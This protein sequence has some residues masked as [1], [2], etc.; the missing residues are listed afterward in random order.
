MQ[1]L[2][3]VEQ[4]CHLTLLKAR[5]LHNV[6]LWRSVH[7]YIHLT[8][9]ASFNICVFS[10]YWIRTFRLPIFRCTMLLTD[11]ADECKLQTTHY[12]GWGMWKHVRKSFMVQ[13]QVWPYVS[14]FGLKNLFV[15]NCTKTRTGNPVPDV[16]PVTQPTVSK[17]W[18]N[19]KHWTRQIQ[20]RTSFFFRSPSDSCTL[21]DGRLTPAP[22][23]LDYIIY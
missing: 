2:F 8:V 12:S 18:R 11:H 9:D 1:V 19:T 4:R 16:L 15:C 14:W 17:H 20:P 21:Y 10:L 3:I 6:A 23:S 5:W 7:L 22:L 13:T